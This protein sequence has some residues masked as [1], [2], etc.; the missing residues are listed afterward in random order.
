MN[1]LIR[2]VV[3]S[4][5]T[6]SVTT[7][8]TYKPTTPSDL[9]SSIQILKPTSP[10]GSLGGTFDPPTMLTDTLC[11]TMTMTKSPTNSICSSKTTTTSTAAAIVQLNSDVKA[12]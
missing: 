1:L 12:A 4:E 5:S 11:R 10:T 7:T 9:M 8:T 2:H 6:P 3:V